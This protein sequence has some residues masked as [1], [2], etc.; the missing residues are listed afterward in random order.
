[1]V[2]QLLDLLVNE[3][4]LAHSPRISFLIFK[5]GTS[6]PTSQGIAKTK[7]ACGQENILQ[8]KNHYKGMWNP[9]KVY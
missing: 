1:M 5:V 7:L 3:T 6:A 8:I 4:R 9:F 2:P